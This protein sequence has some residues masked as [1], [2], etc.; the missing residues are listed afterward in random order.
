MKSKYELVALAKSW[1]VLMASN[2]RIMETFTSKDDAEM[3][4]QEYESGVRVVKNKKDVWVIDGLF[5]TEPEIG[6]MMLGQIESLDMAQFNIVCKLSQSECDEL[7]QEYYEE[8]GSYP[9][10]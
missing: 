10:D 2:G 9:W 8:H 7:L 6:G 5:V 1:V 3:A 4:M